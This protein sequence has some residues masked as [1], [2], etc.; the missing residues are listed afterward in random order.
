[1]VGVS[2][3]GTFQVS[4][5]AP[6]HDVDGSFVEQIIEYW[7]HQGQTSGSYGRMTLVDDMTLST[8]LTA[9]LDQAFVAITAVDAGG[10][11]SSMSNEAV[12]VSQ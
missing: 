2:V 12:F 4:W 3:L 1:M 7:L 11:E 6:T 8:N 9:N 10:Q 5:Q